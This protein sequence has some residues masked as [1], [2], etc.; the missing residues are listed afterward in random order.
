MRHR[1]RDRRVRR[2]AATCAALLALAVAAPLSVTATGSA[3]P[4]PSTATVDED[5]RQYEIHGPSSVADRTAPAA[6][7]VAIDEVDDHAVVVTADTMEA[8][9]PTAWAAGLREQRGYVLPLG[10][11]QFMPTP[12]TASCPER[13]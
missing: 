12:M 4:G 11:R 2:S 7:G 10:I 6:T 3:P 9:P 1:P 13:Q 8:G 5:I